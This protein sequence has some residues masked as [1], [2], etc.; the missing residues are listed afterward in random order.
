M[1]DAS[2]AGGAAV[3]S[4]V[5]DVVGV[6]IRVA[7]EVQTHPVET[8]FTG[9]MAVAL[10]LV[11]RRRK[12]GWC[13]GLMAQSVILGYGVVTGNAGYYPAGV[14]IVIYLRNLWLRRGESWRAIPTARELSRQGCTCTTCCVHGTTTVQVGSTQAS[15]PGPV[16]AQAS[17]PGPMGARASGSG[18]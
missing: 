13:V 18:P 5:G 4:A 15:G 2:R 9:L 6:L 12:L 10:A 8:I 16:G 14:A 7:A 17:G 11:A 3:T 1:F